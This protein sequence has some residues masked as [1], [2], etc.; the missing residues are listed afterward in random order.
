MARVVLFIVLLSILGITKTYSDNGKVVIKQ[1]SRKTEFILFGT[2]IG[3]T[4]YLCK[5]P[6]YIGSIQLISVLFAYD[7]DSAGQAWIGLPA[8][9]Y[10]FT[11]EDS[12]VGSEGRFRVFATNAGL[13][14]VGHYTYKWFFKKENT[15][16]EKIS[17]KIDPILSPNYQ[18]L[19]LTKLF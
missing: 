2:S 16:T 3:I 13:M 4:Y 10:N 19:A 14:L 8:A 6:R 1:P 5:Y 18:G 12:N 15:N 9:I 11:G 7:G 17:L